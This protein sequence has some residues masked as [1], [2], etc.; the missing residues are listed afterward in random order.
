MFDLRGL[1]PYITLKKLIDD[2][3]IGKVHTIMFQ[4]LHPLLRNTRPAW[5]FEAGKHG[6][7]IND[8]AVHGI[9]LALWLTGQ[10][11]V[12]I[13]AARE[14]NAAIADVPHFHDAA[15]LMF[16]MGN[17]CGVIGDVSYLA[18]TKCG[19]SGE[20]YWRVCCHG[21]YGMAE[22]YCTAANVKVAT[23]ADEKSREI[24][25]LA[26]NKS[27]YLDS[28]LIETGFSQGHP[29]ITTQQ[30]LRASRIALNAQHMANKLS[31]Q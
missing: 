10:P 19:F 31:Q 2:D 7:T 28:L 14:W 16:R 8:I 22:T 5:Y 27:V 15:Q 12:E 6:G 26:P 17:G 29:Q 23:H 13:I 4:G 1:A 11:D 3:V 20:Q 30:V 24:P 9:D 18:P 25:L 21:S